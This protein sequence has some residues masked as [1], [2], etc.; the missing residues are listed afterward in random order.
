MHQGSDDLPD[1]QR[2]VFD[3]RWNEC[4]E[5]LVNDLLF[6]IDPEFYLSSQIVDVVIVETEKAN[7]F[8]EIVSMRFVPVAEFWPPLWEVFWPGKSHI[9][10]Q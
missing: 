4:H 8:S 3:S 9:A 7:Q 6:P 2:T 1:A 10:S 5:C